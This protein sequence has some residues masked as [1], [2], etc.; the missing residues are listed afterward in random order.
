MYMSAQDACVPTRL[1]VRSDRRQAKEQ[2]SRL[3]LFRCQKGDGR[4]RK[5]PEGIR[6]LQISGHAKSWALSPPSFAAQMPP[7][8]TARGAVRGGFYL[9]SVQIPLN[10]FERIEHAVRVAALVAV[11]GVDAGADETVADVIACACLLYT[12]PRPRD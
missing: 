12:S 7:P 8:L 5:A 9:L 4:W 3:A 10:R 6:T 1:S 11:A 2:A